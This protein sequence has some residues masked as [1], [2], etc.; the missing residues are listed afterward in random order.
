MISR[1]EVDQA[2][3]EGP[4]VTE[5]EVDGGDRVEDRSILRIR[6]LVDSDTRALLPLLG[7]DS[8][9]SRTA[10]HSPLDTLGGGVEGCPIFNTSSYMFEKVFKEVDGLIGKTAFFQGPRRSLNNVE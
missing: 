1:D 8:L 6:P 7:H 4:T 2:H 5:S 3:P 9:L 10:L